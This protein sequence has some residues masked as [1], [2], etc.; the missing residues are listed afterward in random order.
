M[1]ATPAQIAASP[2]HFLHSFEGADAVIVPMDAAAYRRSIFLDRRISHAPGEVFALPAAT[3]PA[4]LRRS[5]IPIWGRS[6]WC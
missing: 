5:W 6:R 1:P 3:L 4:R 2:D